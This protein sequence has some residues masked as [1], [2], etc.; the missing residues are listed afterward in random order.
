M[1]TVA[2]QETEAILALFN[3]VA[4]LEAKVKELEERLANYEDDNK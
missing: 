2:Q 3:R 4:E 1:K